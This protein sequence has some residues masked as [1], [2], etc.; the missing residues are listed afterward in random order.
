LSILNHFA[1]QTFDE[2]LYLNTARLYFPLNVQ[3]AV[4]WAFSE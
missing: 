4:V 1:E 3:D 2:R